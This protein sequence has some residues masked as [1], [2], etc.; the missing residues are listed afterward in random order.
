MTRQVSTGKKANTYSELAET[1]SIETVVSIEST[2]AKIDTYVRNN[3]LVKNQLDEKLARVQNIIEIAQEFRSNLALRNGINDDV[4][5]L[6]NLSKNYLDQVADNLNASDGGRFL[7]SG[8]RTDA[9]AVS[10]IQSTNIVRGGES[11]SYYDGDNAT[12][13][14]E[15]SDTSAVDF[16]VRA[17]H[18][19][20]K[21]LIGA[22]HLAKTGDE[23]SDDDLVDDAST[24]LEDALT[25]LTEVQLNITN[26]MK[27]VSDS[28]KQH[29]SN[30]LRLQDVLSEMT[31][32][33]IP[34]AMTELTVHETILQASFLTVS[35]I[36][37][38]SLTNFLRS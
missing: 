28:N 21:K 3:A 22:L 31:D 34:A 9:P 16:D 30:K 4:I 11:D 24:M 25:Q 18:S 15:V 12:L 20:F 7:F 38:L 2:M 10:N 23:N 37:Q 29:D 26:D 19:A 5:N 1:A 35:R 36:M 17:N 8:S 32:T 13:S 33:D 27:K 14:V 6:D